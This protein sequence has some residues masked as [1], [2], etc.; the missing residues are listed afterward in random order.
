MLESLASGGAKELRMAVSRP[1]GGSA[2]SDAG[3]GK[4]LEGSGK[5]QTWLHIVCEQPH[6]GIWILIK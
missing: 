6:T 2:H 3:P 4:W 1:R 5:P